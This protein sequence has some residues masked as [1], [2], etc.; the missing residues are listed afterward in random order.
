MNNPPIKFVYDVTASPERPGGKVG[1]AVG[2]VFVGTLVILAV[3]VF[4][5]WWVKSAQSDKM[6]GAE[7]EHHESKYGQHIGQIGYD[8]S[9]IFNDQQYEEF[10]SPNLHDREDAEHETFDGEIGWDGL[11]DV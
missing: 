1:K 8:R 4:I 7:E 9:V 5:M 2:W 10:T 11:G 6:G 3:V